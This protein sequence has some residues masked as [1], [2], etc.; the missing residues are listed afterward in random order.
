MVKFLKKHTCQNLSIP[1]IFE[2]E[3]ATQS[4]I[5]FIERMAYDKG[6]HCDVKLCGHV[7]WKSSSCV[8]EVS[9]NI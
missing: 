3:G 8:K 4:A 2:Y 6:K 1:N 9:C 7:A 5:F